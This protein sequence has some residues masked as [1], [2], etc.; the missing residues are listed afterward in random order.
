[1]DRDKLMNPTETTF[2]ADDA[3]ETAG[4]NR[5]KN[6]EEMHENN[7]KWQLPGNLDASSAKRQLQELITYLMI[8]HPSDVTVIDG[9]H[10]EWTFD[11]K[12]DEEKFKYESVQLAVQIHPIKN[13]QQQIIR[14]VAITRI[15]STTTISDWKNNDQFYSAVDAAD[16][17]IFPHPFGYDEWDTTTVGFIKDI[18]AIHYPRELLHEQLQ[19][20]MKKQNKNIPTFQLIQQRITT[21][22]KKATTKAYTVQC[23]KDDVAQL[24]HLLTHGP[25]RLETNQIFVPFKFKTTKPDLFAKCI[26]QQNEVYRK[27]WII[28][29]E[30]I[31]KEVMEILLPDITTI[32]GVMHVVPSKRLDDIGEWKILV[33]QSKCSYIHRSLTTSWC[34]ILSKVPAEILDA[35]PFTYSVPSISSKRARE[36]QDAESDDDSYGSLLSTGT[37]AST[38]T[39][40]DDAS[41]NDLPDEYKFPSYASATANST[42]TGN[43]THVS[44]PTTSTYAENQREKQLDAQIR[45]Q[46]AE[47]ARIKA[48]LEEKINR[49]KDLEDQLAQA[50]ELAHSRD[51]RHEELL[52]KFETLLKIF[53]EQSHSEKPAYTAKNIQDDSLPTTPDRL[54]AAGPP[55]TKKPNNN[56]SPHRNI[57]SIFRQQ[58]PK[59]SSPRPR[60]TRDP[61]SSQPMDTD[62]DGRQPKLGAKPSNR[63]E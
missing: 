27:T 23:L 54:T 20:M 17:Y 35:A 62:D 49:S 40:D 43:E 36:Y 7:I 51:A 15:Q 29:L 53:S 21:K 42:K 24:I 55:P 34:Q 44:S 5:G 6:G 26:R 38:M 60:K 45:E 41:L 25:F 56:S 61:S 16:T 10:R 63:K 1:M 50:I 48:D 47:I 52:E 33:D 59:E 13:K 2:N 8:S 31:T 46:A 39:N 28:K 9:K 11:E 22:D 14:W 12:E 18:H 58:N 57:Y 3:T 4:S 37:E 32:M 30:G 19:E